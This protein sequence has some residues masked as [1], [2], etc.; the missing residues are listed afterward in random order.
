MKNSRSSSTNQAPLPSPR[1][2]CSRQVTNQSIVTP[3]PRYN[4][5][6]SA[7]DFNLRRNT[8]GFVVDLQRNTAQQCRPQRP[9]LPPPP[10]P[11]TVRI[12]SL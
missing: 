4:R 5:S 9:L 10:D 6:E 7:P 1:Q 8:D 3:R 2:I 11:K 12:L